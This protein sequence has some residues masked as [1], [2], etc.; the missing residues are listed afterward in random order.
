M[1]QDRSFYMG[2][3]AFPYD[4]T[5]EAIIESY[6]NQ[7]ENGDILLT[8]FDH[9]VPWDEALNNLDFPAE[10][11]TAINEAISNK[12]PDHKVLLTATATE[13]DRMNLAK[14]WNDSGAHQ[15]L[16]EFWQD[17]SFNSEE[18]IAAY[19][20]YCHRIIDALQ[21]DYFAYGIEINAAFKANSESF[22]ERLEFADSIYS[23]LKTSYPSLPV[24]LTFQDQSFNKNVVQLHEVTTQLLAYS[25]M[26]AVSTYPFWHYDF[27][28]RDADPEL[29]A[30]D[31]LK[32]MRALTPDK[33]FA[34][35][36][37]GFCTESLV[38]PAYGVYIKG[39][40]NWQNEYVQKLMVEA[41][42]LEAE[43][44]VWFVYR[45]LDRLEMNLP[46]PNDALR[47]WRDN[48]LEDED[49]HPRP[50]H[51]TWSD[52]KALPVNG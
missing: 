15:Q 24:F 21:P 25:D 35:S 7:R 32:D 6:T 1:P 36:E 50:A 49:G 40:E 44:V 42:S 43:F 31:W 48:G 2:F 26:I 28:D 18:V 4:V 5:A 45:D 52:W 41:N 20:N 38:L 33:P 19:K 9:G 29:F 39:N 3:T 27:P 23:D 47:I 30:N 17:K 16:P 11:Q 10:V 8:H 22:S 46:E 37:T 12:T 14:Y 13:T 34:I 51:S